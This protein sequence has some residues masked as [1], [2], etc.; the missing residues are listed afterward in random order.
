MLHRHIGAALQMGDAAD[1]GAGDDVGLELAQVAE[2]AVAQVGGQAGV[3]PRL[4]AGRAAAQMRFVV[5]HA[6]F[7]TQRIQ[8]GFY[9]AF[10]LLSVLHGARRVKRHR[11]KKPAR[12]RIRGY[13]ILSH[14]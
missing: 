7:E 11:P 1:V 2:L 9:A 13:V 10:E 8:M 14:P 3:E 12:Y 5:G 4:G 6:Q